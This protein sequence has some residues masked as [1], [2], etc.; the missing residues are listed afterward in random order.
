MDVINYNYNVSKINLNKY[1]LICGFGNVFQKY[2]DSPHEKCIA[3]ICYGTGM[4]LFFQNQA[5]LNRVKDVFIKK[6]VWL[7]DSSRY[8]KNIKLHQ[9]TLVNGII[10]IGNDYC[11]ESY[12]EH[13]LGYV[14]SVPGVFF[15]TQ[16]AIKIMNNRNVSSSNNFLWFGSKGLIH[17]GLDL[18]LDHFKANSNITL[19]ICGDIMREENFVKIYREELFNTPNIICHGFIDI[20]SERFERILELCSFVI[21]PSCSEGGCPSVLTAIGNGGL[22]PIISKETTI[23]TG[24]EIL[25]STLDNIGI[26]RAIEDSQSLSWSQ[27]IKLQKLNYQVVVENNNQNKY[28]SALKEAITNILDTTQNS[29]LR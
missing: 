16:N 4:H 7:G 8:V 25:I 17:K 19:H 22:I 26:A 6:N 12:R 2:F 5:T 28:Y 21:F 23:S 18:L 15:L 24:Y 1:D 13:F 10:A 20:E 9:T 27:I 14:Y 11:A 3:T 29:Y